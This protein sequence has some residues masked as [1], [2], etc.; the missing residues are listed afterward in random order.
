M[1]AGLLLLYRAVTRLMPSEYR[2]RHGDAGLALLV[3]LLSDAE[4][5]GGW[6]RVGVAGCSAI[7]DAIVRLPAEH[8]RGRSAWSVEGMGRDVRYAVRSLIFRPL[9][10]ALAIATLALA[11]GLNA[12]VF[13][14]L[15]WTL[16]RPLPYPAPQELVRIGSA[17]IGP[18]P[19]RS[20][21]TYSEFSLLSS[22]TALRS[23]VRV[24]HGYPHPY[25]ARTGAR[26]CGRRARVRRPLQ[27]PGSVPVPRTWLRA[28]RDFIRRGHR[29]RERRTV[30][31]ALRRRCRRRRAHGGARR[32]APHESSV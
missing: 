31:T 7:V 1:K 17:A 13:S 3:R 32:R 15:D 24:L 19:G 8:L 14:V 2:R 11:I 4:A 25:R 22:A 12:A 27:D 5:D 16:L 26:S 29:R 21:L 20:E 23:S 10:G 28:A 6:S 9:A 18:T 30:A